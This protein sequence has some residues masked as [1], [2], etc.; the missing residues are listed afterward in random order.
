M[1]LK[2][3]RKTKAAVD[4][5][6]FVHVFVCARPSEPGKRKSVDLCRFPL[7]GFKKYRNPELAYCLVKIV[8]SLESFQM[9]DALFNN[10]RSGKPAPIGLL[11]ALLSGDERRRKLS[12]EALD[13]ADTPSYLNAALALSYQEC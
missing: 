13:D 9:S 12:H 5:R 2:R 11:V 1:P 10:W 3:P 6:G 7:S 8:C 4:G